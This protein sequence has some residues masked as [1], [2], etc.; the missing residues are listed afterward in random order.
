MLIIS[1]YTIFNY[2]I[3]VMLYIKLYFSGLTEALILFLAK[4]IFKIVPSYR[5]IL[6]QFI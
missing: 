1:I 6:N 2:F 3:G 5:Y 4:V